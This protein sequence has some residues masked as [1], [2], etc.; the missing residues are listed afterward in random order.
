MQSYSLDASLV[1]FTASERERWRE[2]ALSSNVHG[3]R[4]SEIHV[5]LRSAHRSAKRVCSLSIFPLS[6]SIS[7]F[8]SL[9]LCV[10]CL[11]PCLRTTIGAHTVRSTMYKVYTQ[12]VKSLCR[13][14]AY[15]MFSRISLE[16]KRAML[17]LS[18]SLRPNERETAK[19]AI[20]LVAIPDCL[21]RQ[22]KQKQR[23]RARERER[24]T[25]TR[26]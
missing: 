17:S 12:H 6:L 2:T 11:C 3:Y 26:L 25:H 14:Q 21:S 9:S 22:I 7:L 10:R 18:C 1:R 20:S 16:P 19:V 24:A 5:Y 13:V 8:C 15:V 4:R 23:K